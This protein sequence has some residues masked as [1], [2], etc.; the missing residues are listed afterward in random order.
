MGRV[1]RVSGMNG[2]RWLAFMLLAA[3]VGCAPKPEVAA[4]VHGIALPFI[5]DDFPHAIARAREKGLPLFVEVWAP[6]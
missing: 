6:W 4:T 5:E 1:A 2:T 3:V